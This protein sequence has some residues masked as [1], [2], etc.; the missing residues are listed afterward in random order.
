MTLLIGLSILALA[1]MIFYLAADN[2]RLR[3]MVSKFDHNGDGKPGGS[4]KRNV[5]R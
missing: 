2:V 4:K 5:T 1:A 3:S